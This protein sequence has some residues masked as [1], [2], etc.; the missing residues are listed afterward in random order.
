MIIKW[1]CMIE[2]GV[3]NNWL[4]ISFTTLPPI[5]AYAPITNEKYIFKKSDFSVGSCWVRRGSC[6]IF[7]DAKERNLFVKESEPRAQYPIHKDKFSPLCQPHRPTTCA[8][9]PQENQRLNQ[10]VIMYE[11]W[12][13]K[14]GLE[15]WSLQ[16]KFCFRI[17]S[18][19]KVSLTFPSLS[20]SR[21]VCVC[22]CVCVCLDP[23]YTS[24]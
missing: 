13:G 20:I 21:C 16:V 18:G 9:R 14:V 3:N 5:R 8:F 10:Y 7:V 17:K 22:E 24:K 15:F 19:G 2:I 23:C 6:G 1:W 12:I 4:V 11:E